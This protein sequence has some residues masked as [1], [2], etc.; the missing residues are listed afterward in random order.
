MRL[1]LPSFLD[2]YWRDP[3]HEASGRVAMGL[4][5]GL[6]AIGLNAGIRGTITLVW[7]HMYRPEDFHTWGDLWQFM[8]NLQT[9]ISPF[10]AFWEISAQLLFGSTAVFEYGLYPLCIGLNAY[11][12]TVL[13]A[14]TRPQILLMAGLSLVFAV[15][16]RFMH[17][18]NPQI[19][20]ITMPT[21]I[22]GWLG[23]L[24]RLRMPALTGSA[25][26]RMSLLAGLLLSMLEL[27]RTLIFPLLP[28]FLLLTCLA[29][30]DVPAP[31]WTHRLRYVLAFLV[32]ILLFSGGWH[33]KQLVSHDQLHWSN[34]DG[35]N[36][37]KSWSEF[38]GPVPTD[39]VDDPPLYPGGMDNFNTDRHTAYN[40]VMQK[41]V[42]AAI[43][44]QPLRA[45]GHLGRRLVAFYK[46]K[47]ELFL[48]HTPRPFDW[49]YRPAVWLCGLAMV[50]GLLWTKWLT[51][52]NL[53]KREA[54]LRLGRPEV[55][56]WVVT[57]LISS[58]FAVGEVGEEARFMISILPLLAAGA[59]PG[60]WVMRGNATAA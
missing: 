39:F 24:Q 18:G 28:F 55:I 32:P 50:W 54:W 6:L 37:Q 4:L 47:T 2:R 60:L 46:P 45:A 58:V 19:Y 5:V 31:R 49:I 43:L 36:M 22:L 27:T 20:D 59:A 44:A 53:R 29:I 14:R 26:L 3:V 8:G 33:L 38:T 16:I 15:A 35:F 23:C 25:R 52:R 9:G 30:A 1:V 41:Q 57:L 13:F 42:R 10:W 40:K 17:K 21:M 51:L 11:L 12:A 34:H 56:L 48:G 7:Q